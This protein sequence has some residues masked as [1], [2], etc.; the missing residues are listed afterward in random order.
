MIDIEHKNSDNPKI[1]TANVGNYVF[2]SINFE[3]KPVISIIPVK[4]KYGKN[5]KLLFGLGKHIFLFKSEIIAKG[6][7]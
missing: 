6:Q 2:L 4:I 3:P 7:F 5:A 1:P